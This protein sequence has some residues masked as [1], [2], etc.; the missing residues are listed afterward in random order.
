MNAADRFA[1]CLAHVLGEEGG[2][3]NDPNDAG[4]R[5]NRGI[6]EATLRAAAAQ[7]IVS[8]NDVAL[9]TR[10][11]VEA[12]Y[13]TFYWNRAHCYL[14]PE[15]L[16]LLMFDAAVNCGVG[17]AVRFLQSAL[18]FCMGAQLAVDGVFGPATAKA[19]D[20]LKAGGFPWAKMLCLAF[21]AERMEH[22][23]R[24]TDGVVSDPARKQQEIRNRA[25]LRGWFSRLERLNEQ[26]GI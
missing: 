4:G 17:T 10:S 24:I 5:T 8:C 23:V 21:N 2:Y 9:L 16:D 1:A 22:Y 12:I 14:L 11:D 3:S 20:A 15:P 26:A 18:S 13:R 19:L 6:T 7:G 25:F